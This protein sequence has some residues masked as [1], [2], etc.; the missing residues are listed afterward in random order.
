M[1]E[2]KQLTSEQIE[3][4]RTVLCGQIGPY[5]FMMPDEEIQQLREK[6]QSWCEDLPD[7][8]DKKKGGGLK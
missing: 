7:K 5:A 2:K 8:P 4:W 1:S 6:M 3:N